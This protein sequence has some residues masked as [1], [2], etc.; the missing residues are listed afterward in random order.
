M[1]EWLRA[2]L[3]YVRAALECWGYIIRPYDMLTD[4]RRWRWQRPAECGRRAVARLAPEQ[5]EEIH[6][7][8]QG[9]APDGDR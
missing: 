4:A 5:L 3:R 7:A 6:R 2:E 8:I 1:G 9:R